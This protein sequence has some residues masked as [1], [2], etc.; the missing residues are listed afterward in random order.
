MKAVVCHKSELAV[1]DIPDPKPGKGQVLIEVTRAGICGTDLHHV[2]HGDELAD[3]SVEVGYDGVG[4]SD[5]QVIFGHEFTGTVLEY[6]PDC[7]KSI[8]AGRPVVAL[9]YLRRDGGVHPIGSSVAA[10]G[11]YAE[12]ML[13]EEALMFEVPNGIGPDIAALTEPLAIAWHAVRCGEVQEDNVAI[14]IGCG[15]VGLG[16]IALLKANGVRTVVASDNNLGRRLLAKQC[17][18]DVVVDPAQGSPYAGAQE[19]GFLE[20]APP[21]F[22]RVVGAMEQ[23]RSMPTPWHEIARAAEAAGDTKPKGPVIF[24]CVGVPGAIEQ[25]IANAPLFSRVVVAGLCMSE[26]HFR[27]A[28]GVFKTI[29]LRFVRGFTPLEFWDC[30]QML[31]D[32]KIDA[33]P[34]V[35]GVVGLA[36]VENA[37]TALSERPKVHA[38]ILIDPKSQAERP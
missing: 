38:K 8:L 25:I 23:L 17:G 4:R 9:P 29:D 10:P 16:I 36:G 18:A 2:H 20:T 33:T 35:T 7:R 6:G 12:R 1:T 5:Q 27:P 34:F 11:A 14:V 24:E 32:G 28:M 22:H 19:Y 31:A 37:F 3:V 21:A 26:D 30:L 13:V 15:P